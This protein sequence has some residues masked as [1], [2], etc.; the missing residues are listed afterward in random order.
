M[1]PV[2]AHYWWVLLFLEASHTVRQAGHRSGYCN[3]P[4][5]LLGGALQACNWVFP[6]DPPRLPPPPINI[7]LIN[8][9]CLIWNTSD[10]LAFSFEFQVAGHKGKVWT[11]KV[12]TS[13]GYISSHYAFD[14][15]DLM[16]C[17]PPTT[18][19]GLLGT[20]LNTYTFPV[21]PEIVSLRSL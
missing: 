9:R 20:K 18:H 12:S 5:G 13:S 2:A 6:K 21:T 8:H 10:S 19:T 16:G 1:S 11:L 15:F 3:P 14:C 4:S 17:T 7:M